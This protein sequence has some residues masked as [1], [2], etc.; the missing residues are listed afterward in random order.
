MNCQQESIY[1]RGKA[2]HGNGE[3]QAERRLLANLLIYN[4]YFT[5]LS[6]RGAGGVKMCLQQIKKRNPS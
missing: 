3:K 5:P 4:W 1:G 2:R 6:L